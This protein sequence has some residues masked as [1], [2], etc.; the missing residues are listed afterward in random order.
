MTEG[1]FKTE[2]E[3]LLNLIST[4][5]YITEAQS[6]V[7]NK[8][9]EIWQLE[10]A[11][12]LET[13]RDPTI[14]CHG[15]FIATPGH[16]EPIRV[17]LTKGLAG[18]GKT[19]NVQEFTQDWANGLENQD[20]NLLIPL[21][22]S[23]LNLIKDEEHSLHTVVL[24]FHPFLQQL[25]AEM[26][27]TCNSLFILDGLNESR[28]SLDFQ[29]D[30]IVSDVRQKSSVPVLLT[31]LIKG[32]LLKS[33]NVWITSRPAAASQIPPNYVDR[34]TEIRGFTDAQ[35]EEYIRIRFTD[36][37]LC[38]R[39]LSHIKSSRSLD[40]MCQIPVCCRITATVLDHT[41]STDQSKVLPM[42][43][44]SLY[45]HFLV[46]QTKPWLNAW[47]VLFKLGKLAFE[48][49]EAGNI[50][51][52]EDLEHYA[53]DV[54]DTCVVPGVLEKVLKI[55]NGMYNTGEDFMHVR[56][57]SFTHWSI[58]EFLAAFYIFHCYTNSNTEV[59]KGFFCVD[60]DDDDDDLFIVEDNIETNTFRYPSSLDIFLKKAMA[61]SLESEH[62]HLDLFVRFLYGLSLM[63]NQT[64]FREVLSHA[65][66]SSKITQKVLEDLKK[67]NTNEISPDRS[68]NLFSCLMELEDQSVHQEVQMF[69]KSGDKPKQRLSDIY[70]SA[71]AYMLLTTEEVL[72]ELDLNKYRASIKGKQRLLPAVRNTRRAR[73]VLILSI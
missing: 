24:A 29:N 46:D 57:Y 21:P 43:M 72:D 3:T 35:K 19:F 4:D 10:T 23:K 9:H 31:N 40:I 12:K 30:E 26:L 13:L 32:K 63:S 41:L 22:F 39:I 50:F 68:M 60:D 1:P 20:V 55:E 66:N 47:N 53:L 70:C 18:V 65:D 11:S 51:Y 38:S 67:W 5:L 52:Q 58:Q 62:G 34:F 37:E 44:T 54:R 61:K 45:S 36:Q 6:E 49:L 17:V 27:A 56:M 71:L 8:Q 48:R 28:F 16:R 33:A 15:I 64:Q 7:I 59:L 42:T 2:S 14:S 69:L 73:L 25:T